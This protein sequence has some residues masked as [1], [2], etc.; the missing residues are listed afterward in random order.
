M[1]VSCAQI[2]CEMSRNNMKMKR[3]TFILDADK[4]GIRIVCSAVIS[5]DECL[6]NR[7]DKRLFTNG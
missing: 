1:A 5:A 4:E 3:L 2:D 6:I 7:L